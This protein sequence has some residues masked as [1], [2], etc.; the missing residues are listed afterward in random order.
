MSL[1]GLICIWTIVGAIAYMVLLERCIAD[2]SICNNIIC[3]T[4]CGPAVWIIVAIVHGTY[5]A[6][7]RTDGR[8]QHARGN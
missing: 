1:I 2:S 6:A 4:L 5:A 3:T 8:K 7:D